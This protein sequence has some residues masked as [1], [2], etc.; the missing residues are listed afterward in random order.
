MRRLLVLIVAAT[1]VLG[2]TA[3]GG[4]A[5]ASTR[6][7]LPAKAVTITITSSGCAGG[8]E[9]CFKPAKV[10]V[11]PGTKVIW[12]NTTDSAHTVTRCTVADCG[13]R[14]GTGTDRKLASPTIDLSE[15][16]AFTFKHL[17]TYVYYCQFHGYTG[18]HG[19]VTV[20]AKVANPSTTTTTRTT[21]TAT[22]STTPYPYTAP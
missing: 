6:A 7:V 21:T 19:T 14:G 2:V 18:M 5:L 16:F 20:R 10:T 4:G 17:G 1:V 22:M 11:Q 3:V 8:A 9:F 15:R 12:K 13:V